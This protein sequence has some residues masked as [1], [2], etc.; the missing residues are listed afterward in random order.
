MP[1]SQKNVSFLLEPANSCDKSVSLLVMVSS[2]PCNK[3]NR[4][5]WRRDVQNLEGVRL[6]FLVSRSVTQYDQTKL[7]EEHSSYGDIVQS[8][9]PDGHRQ[10]GYKILTG[11]VWV[12]RNCPHVWA[13]AKTDDNVHLDMHYIVEVTTQRKITENTIACTVPN[14]N[15]KTLRASRPHMR[16][17]WSVS[18]EE[19]EED[20]MPDFCTGFL[21]VTTPRVGSALV[22]AGLALYRDTKT[23]QIED[24]LITGILRE[25][26]SSVHLDTLEHGL[27]ARLWLNIFSHC[28]WITGFKITF[29]NS[30]VISKI[31]SRS[32]V[33]YV[34]PITSPKVW[35]YFLCLHYEGILELMDWAVV[36]MV[37]H[38]LW[39]LCSR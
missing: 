31:S 38:A 14:R 20:I 30:P 18:K 21:Y 32:N 36:G 13:V 10:L 3:V 11:Y 9:L 28:P 26:L 12:A 5:R 1:L 33:Q 4:D 7:S 24:S 22:Q 25:R 15:L 39:D 34:G 2:G 8:S 27:M 16:G 37:P 23:E 29:F 35:R 17:N 6:V 19:Y